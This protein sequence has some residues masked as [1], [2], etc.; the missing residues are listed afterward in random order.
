MTDQKEWYRRS[1]WTARDR[2]EFNARLARSRGQ[3]RKA[4]YLRLQAYHLHEVG[5]QHLLPG[6]LE[7]LDRLV[8]EFPEPFQLGL[9][10]SL[11]AEVLVDLGRSD[12]ALVSYEQALSARR[13]FPAVCDD[14]YLGYVE[15]I[16]ALK[17][18]LLAHTR[19]ET[20]AT[21]HWARTALEAADRSESPFRYHRRLGLVRGADPLLLQRPTYLAH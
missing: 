14:A 15:L 10:F 7:L 4:Q 11:R 16:L 1:T 20:T 21:R 3:D 18:A 19:G 5:D 9:A 2:E 8:S 17:R 6:A 13:S 12:A